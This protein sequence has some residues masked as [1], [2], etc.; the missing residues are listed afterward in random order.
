MDN[1]ETEWPSQKT[2]S[3]IQVGSGVAFATFST[4]HLVN[5]LSANF[6]YVAYN[7][8]QGA[9]RKFYQNPIVEIALAGALIAHVSTSIIKIWR[10]QKTSEKPLITMEL[11]PSSLHRYTGYFLVGVIGGHV[12]A[13][14]IIPLI[15][16]ETVDFSL[17]SQTLIRWPYIFYP[18]YFLLATCGLYHTCYGLLRA[19]SFFGIQVPTVLS[20]HRTLFR[21][22]IGTTSV[23]LG[24]SLLA[25]GGWYFPIPTNRFETFEKLYQLYMPKWML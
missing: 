18:Y 17:V 6:G 24:S 8:L 2:L 14:R 23:A 25:F 12:A 20:T 9:L 16:K 7:S 11:N 19:C 1:K 3:L 13:T 10:R 4:V 21:A 5:T 22:F 15:L